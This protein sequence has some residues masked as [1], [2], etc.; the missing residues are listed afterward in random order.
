MK[1]RP[2]G[3]PDASYLGLTREITG[4]QQ[5]SSRHILASSL[6]GKLALW[7]V[8][9]PEQPMHYIITPDGQ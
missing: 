5:I 9:R 8:T 7:D 4:L 2:K 1:A 3:V 6:E